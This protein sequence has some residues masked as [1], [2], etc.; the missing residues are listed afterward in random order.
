MDACK[1]DEKVTYGQGGV[2]CDSLRGTLERVVCIGDT[3]V[4][5]MDTVKGPGNGGT[6]TGKGSY[7][8]FNKDF[9]F[10]LKKDEVLPA[11][12][13]GYISVNA[14]TKALASKECALAES[15]VKNQ[16]FL[17]GAALLDLSNPVLAVPYINLTNHPV[18]IKAGM[19]LAHGTFIHE[20]GIFDGSPENPEPELRINAV[21]P[22]I[23]KRTKSKSSSLQVEVDDDEINSSNKGLVELGTIPKKGVNVNKTV[24]QD[25][26][27]RAKQLIEDGIKRSEC[28]DSL[29]PR[30][31]ALL[32]KHKAVLA[33]KDDKP[34]Y[35][36]LYQP[37]IN[38][39]TD[40]PIYQAQYP[41][42]FQ[43]RKL[44]NETVSKFLKD[45]IVQ[46]SKSP[47]NA[48][49]I[50]V[51]IGTRMCVDFRRLNA[52]LIT[53]HHPLPRISQILE[54]L[55]GA[56]YLTALDLLH[57]FYNLMINPADRYKTAFSTPNGHYEFVRLPMGLKNSP[58][59][60]QRVMNLVLTY[61]IGQIRFYLH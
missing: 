48:P 10:Y 44:I 33:D 37:S 47:Y 1:S 27:Q 58:S 42:P 28:P 59:I 13:A 21:I 31:R 49:T 5:A 8:G 45:G 11:N 20:S 6:T 25:F 57:G 14:P 7:K 55:G 52:H 41:I 34:G 24:A 23:K 2:P 61:G 18:Q 38:L 60:F 40:V 17:V 51:D 56:V 43:M 12:S 35:C 50:I 3:Q 26:D 19:F 15:C 46:H 54:Q 53:D 4:S 39:D 32:L 22:N 16:P 36:D 9:Y 29:V 30:L